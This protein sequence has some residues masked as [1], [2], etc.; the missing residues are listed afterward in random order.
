MPLLRD[1]VLTWTWQQAL[2]RLAPT[3]IRG[4]V[5]AAFELHLKPYNHGHLP[6]LSTS[7]EAQGPPCARAW[8]IHA[9]QSA[10]LPCVMCV[11]PAQPAALLFGFS[12]ALCA[13]ILLPSYQPPANSIA[14]SAAHNDKRGSMLITTCVVQ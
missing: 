10:A 6:C 13:R 14:A 3:H 11:L 1:N 2:E 7:A 5:G 8:D 12:M 9:L 4:K